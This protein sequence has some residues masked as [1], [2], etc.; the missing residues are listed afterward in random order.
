MSTYKF[1]LNESNSECNPSFLNREF[2]NLG[3]FKTKLIEINGTTNVGELAINLRGGSD[4]RKIE[5]SKFRTKFF[6][7][8]EIYIL[9][10]G[11]ISEFEIK[12][13]PGFFK[14]KIE[15]L[16]KAYSLSVYYE[17]DKLKR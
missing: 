4:E 10:T 17:F 16:L 3:I 13:V 5:L 12:S 15:T 14:F 11:D 6:L 7:Q 1:E 9:E 2:L 8:N